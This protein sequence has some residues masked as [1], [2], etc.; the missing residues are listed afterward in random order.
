VCASCEVGGLV[1]FAWFCGQIF[2][3]TKVVKC[4]MYSLCKSYSH[5]LKI[6]RINNM[7]ID[8]KRALYATVNAN[9][10]AMQLYL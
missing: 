2:K 6:K 5:K 9:R 10:T 8:Q 7:A 4:I 3:M 1:S